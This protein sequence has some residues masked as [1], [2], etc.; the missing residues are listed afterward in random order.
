MIGSIEQPSSTPNPM[1]RASLDD[2]GLTLE[3]ASSKLGPGWQTL[4]IMFRPLETENIIANAIRALNE[5]P[6][7]PLSGLQSFLGS[8]V[9]G[10]YYQGDFAPYSPFSSPLAQ[11]PIYVGKAIE[12]GG[13]T[14]YREDAMPSATLYRRLQEHAKSIEQACNLKLEHF[15][16][17]YLVL[18]KHWIEQTERG[19][20]TRY[21]PLWNTMVTGFGN[22]DPGSGRHAGLE[23][24]WDALH[25]GRP[26]AQKLKIRGYASALETYYTW[27]D[28][29]TRPDIL[30][31]VA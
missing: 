19:L 1:I 25:S 21:R 20:I 11:V 2:R 17:R 3:A 9:Y 23:S 30:K 15:V 5:S 26:W 28:E 7:R 27:L 31:K 29:I 13:R 4:S 22:H 6:T 18:E 16:C 10:I 14:G 12:P 8:G 24:L